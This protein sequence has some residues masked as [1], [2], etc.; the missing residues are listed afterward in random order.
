[1]SLYL[2]I[3]RHFLRISYCSSDIGLPPLILKYH[4][5][6]WCLFDI[7]LLSLLVFTYLLF[8]CCLYLFVSV[9]VRVVW[10]WTESGYK[11]TRFQGSTFGHILFSPAFGL[12]FQEIHIKL[13][14]KNSITLLQATW[15]TNQPTKSYVF[16]VMVK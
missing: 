5:L 15:V 9:Y 7:W 11:I 2:S 8:G 16:F 12:P 14:A 3:T 1:M 6:S 13:C 10:Y 4:F